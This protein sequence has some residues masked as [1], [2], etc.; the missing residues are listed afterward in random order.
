MEKDVAH[1]MKITSIVSASVAFILTSLKGVFVT[2][3]ECR[4]D[5]SKCVDGIKE[6]LIK[7]NHKI[8]CMNEDT[9]EK[10]NNTGKWITIIAREL[11][12]KQS[13]LPDL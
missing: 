11:K 4:R 6:E 1:W 8:D 3:G 5:K 7:I 9:Q 2:R 13:D 10:L 12:I